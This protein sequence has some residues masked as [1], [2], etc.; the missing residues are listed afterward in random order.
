MTNLI[1]QYGERI[2]SLLQN[3]GASFQIAP[4]SFNYQG[5]SPRTDYS[6]ILRDTKE[7]YQER[8]FHLLPHS[9]KA[10]NVLLLLPFLLL[11][12]KLI[13]LY[14]IQSLLLTIQCVVWMK[15]EKNIP[16]LY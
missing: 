13:H 4:M 3:F 14:Q 11:K 1:Q 2:N 6:L 8:G 15:I 16:D 7:I 10:I 5:G 12:L 9:V